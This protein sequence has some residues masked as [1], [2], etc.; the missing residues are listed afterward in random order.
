MFPGYPS[1]H[2]I[3]SSAFAWTLINLGFDRKIYDKDIVNGKEVVYEYNS[4]DQYAER[5]S[6]SRVY[7]GIHIVKDCEAG[8]SIG[9][10]LA[11]ELVNK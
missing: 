6:I 7:G 8:Y 2:S 11:N 5:A 9:K 1:G 10:E 3:Q 4:L